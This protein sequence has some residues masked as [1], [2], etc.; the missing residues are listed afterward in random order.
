M[1]ICRICKIEKNY[2]EFTQNPTGKDGYRNYCKKC[3]VDQVSFKRKNN[4]E[5]FKEIDL[6]KFY[7][8]NLEEYYTMLMK[9]NSVCAICNNKENTI[10]NLSKRP[11]SLAVDHRHSTGKIRGLLCQK[12][13]QAIG[14]FKEDIKILK[15]AIKYLEFHNEN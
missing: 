5:L 9:Q 2:D 13:N 7:G 4:P 12:C 10:H 1:K 6:K 8:I 14:L 3:R 15:N 11:K